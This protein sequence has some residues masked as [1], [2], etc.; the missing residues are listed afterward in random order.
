MKGT[1]LVSA[2][3]GDED[4]GHESTSS[5]DALEQQSCTR[6]P[7]EAGEGE[8]TVDVVLYNKALRKY[9]E[10]REEHNDLRKLHSNLIAAHSEAVGKLE[11]V[12]VGVSIPFTWATE[13]A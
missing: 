10:L 13:P 6:A 8:V 1:A 11:L 2:T 12:Q 3:A 4:P 5:N 9:E 7:D